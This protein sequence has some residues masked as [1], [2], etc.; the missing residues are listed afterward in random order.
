MSA[1]PLDL[2]AV[3]KRIGHM[4]M[5]VRP[6]IA[7]VRRLREENTQIDTVLLDRNLELGRLE[8]LLRAWGLLV[9]ERVERLTLGGVDREHERD[10]HRAMDAVRA[11]AVE[12]A[13]ARRISWS[14]EGAT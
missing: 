7:E 4:D 1:K 12:I 3:E 2:D 11:E 8:G 5:D 10:E 13:R 6:L 14:P 9:A